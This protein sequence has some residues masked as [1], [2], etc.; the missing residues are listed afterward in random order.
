MCQLS[1]A[2]NLNFYFTNTALICLLSRTFRQCLEHTLTR[3][4]PS[5]ETCPSVDAFWQVLFRKWKCREQLWSDVT[6]CTTLK[7]T[8]DSRRG[9]ETCL[10]TLVHASG[11]QRIT[12][13]LGPVLML[14][15]AMSVI[16]LLTNMTLWKKKC[17]LVLTV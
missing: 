17:I 10:C 12:G 4:A 11:N 6:T 3:N 5:Q 16:L 7:S 1:L 9:I 8:R 13:I 14:Y 2:L 15:Y